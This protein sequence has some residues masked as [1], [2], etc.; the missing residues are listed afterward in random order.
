[1]R[2]NARQGAKC[3]NTIVTM[4]KYVLIAFI[5]IGGSIIQA[6][7]RV[8]VTNRRQ[9][10]LLPE[11]DLIAMSQQ[12]YAE[13]LRTGNVLPDS[14]SRTKL[15]KK[16]GNKMKE[17][18][19][20]FLMSNKKYAKRLEGFQWE[21]NVIDEDIA[22]AW[23]M[24]GGKVCV[25]TGILPITKDEAGLAVVMGHEIAHAIA[26]H[27]NERM[28][29]QIALQAGGEAL[30]SL[31]STKPG[32]A[33]DIFLQSYGVGSQLGALSFSRKNESEADHMGLVFMAVAGY[34]PKSA[35]E[36]WER[37][38][39]LSGANVPEFLSTHPSHDTRIEDIKEH[40]PEAMT[41]Y[42]GK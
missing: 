17:A 25:Y 28:S 26:K 2:G 5:L 32:L 35:V 30:G 19:T 7:S 42:S 1:M 33:R 34:N 9:M 20:S 18:V 8:P 16:V 3:R 36:F 24:P 23:C 31:T 39:S 27:G 11:S 15:V 40:L 6:C 38:K 13:V 37:M 10:N 41:Y 21:F 12:Q 22:N 14:D 29:K 4:K